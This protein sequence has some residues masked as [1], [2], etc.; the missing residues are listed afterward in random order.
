M[1]EPQFK[2]DPIPPNE[3]KDRI[4]T[5]MSERSEDVEWLRSDRDSRMARENRTGRTSR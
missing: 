2:K 1:R 5:A 4:G 3:P